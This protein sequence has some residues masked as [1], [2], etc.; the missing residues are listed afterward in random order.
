[1]QNLPLKFHFLLWASLLSFVIC[2]PPTQAIT[3]QR[4]KKILCKSY[5]IVVC[6]Y[7]IISS[8]IYVPLHKQQHFKTS[9][10]IVKNGSKYMA[11][12]LQIPSSVGQSQKSFEKFHKDLI[13][14]SPF[15]NPL[16]EHPHLLDE[17]KDDLLAILLHTVAWAGGIFLQVGL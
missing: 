16:G 7:L 4:E 9:S 6:A 8:S 2:R 3:A 13:G 17:A 10:K 12:S 5:K 1:M 11:Q 14:F 15:V